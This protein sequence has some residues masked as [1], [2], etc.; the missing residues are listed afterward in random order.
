[1][2]TG[3]KE[4]RKLPREAKGVADL[5]ERGE[6]EWKRV[7]A[8]V[9]FVVFSRDGDELVGRVLVIMVKWKEMEKE[10]DDVDVL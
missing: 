4:V 7:V 8:E 3:L 2:A 1:M 5:R 9:V 10:E 6:G